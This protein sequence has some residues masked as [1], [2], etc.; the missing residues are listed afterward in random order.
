MREL[1]EISEEI[2]KCRACN[3]SKF[4]KN[5]VPGSGGFRKKVLLIGEAPGFYEDLKGEPF[6]GAAGKFL[7]ELLSIAGLGREDVFI[8]NVVKCRPPNNRRP[9]SQEIEKCKRFLDKQIEILKPRVIITL[10]DV[11]LNY[12][13]K[14]LKLKRRS[15]SQIH[16]T[17]FNLLTYVWIPT[18]HPAAAL[19]NPK[20]KEEI[21]EDWK[22]IKLILEKNER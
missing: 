8:T 5:P 10:G 16:G 18:Y 3:L 20:K 2:K 13:L 19:H 14:K 11:A 4:R 6:V 21:L 7:D 9:T 15:I 1:V 22:K 12:M 17:P